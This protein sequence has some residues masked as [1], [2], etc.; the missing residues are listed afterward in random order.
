METWHFRKFRSIQITTMLRTVLTQKLVVRVC[1]FSFTSSVISLNPSDTVTSSVE[2]ILG[3]DNGVRSSYL[4]KRSWIN[5]ASWDSLKIK[6]ILLNLV[7]WTTGVCY[8][9][10]S[11]I[12]RSDEL[13]PL[14]CNFVVIS[15]YTS[16]WGC[17]ST[18]L[19]VIQWKLRCICSRHHIISF[20]Y[21]C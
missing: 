5:R 14:G 11:Y 21:A 13:R 9:P 1:S 19:C 7:N 8:N 17:G 15:L 16:T 10:S 6:T 18:M 12:I 4:F 3:R 2:L 20:I